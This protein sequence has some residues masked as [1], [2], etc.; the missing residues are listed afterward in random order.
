MLIVWNLNTSHV[1]V[2]RDYK[3]IKRQFQHNLN[4]SHFNVNQERLSYQN[5]YTQFKYISC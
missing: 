1:N 3:E 4:T 2:N 5:K